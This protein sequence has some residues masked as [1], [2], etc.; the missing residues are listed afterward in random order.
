M[1]STGN[2]PRV[3]QIEIERLQLPSSSGSDGD[4]Q[5][6]GGGDDEISIGI[7][8]VC[9]MLTLLSWCWYAGSVQVDSAEFWLLYR[10]SSAKVCCL[11]QGLDPGHIG[12]L[13]ISTNKCEM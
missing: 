9:S 8:V 10:F 6:V 11:T 12:Y 13:M 2:P 4:R 3:V 5:N 7:N 1:V